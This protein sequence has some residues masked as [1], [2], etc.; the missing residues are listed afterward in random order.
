MRIDYPLEKIEHFT[1]GDSGS[2]VLF[3]HGWGGTLRSLIGLSDPISAHRKVISIALPGFGNSPEPTTDWGT[4]EYAEVIHRWI[5]AQGLSAIDIV[6]HSFGGRV[7]MGIAHKHPESVNRLVLI[8][9]SGLLLPRG[10]MVILKVMTARAIKHLGRLMGGVLP[11]WL[12]AQRQ[13][14]GSADWK[15]ATPM[16]RRILSRVIREDLSAELPEI[17]SKTLLVWGLEDFAVP[18]K[19]GRQMNKMIPDSK[20]FILPDTGH[21]PFID[22]PGKTL[23]EIWNWLELPAP[24]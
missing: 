8:G 1:A 13:K 23:T 21:Y 16:M 14:L 15:A 18:V 3:L 12:H 9:S 17:H 11:E 19:L 5:R 4:W 6:G 2:S 22:Q 7:A 20:L 24:W 10:P